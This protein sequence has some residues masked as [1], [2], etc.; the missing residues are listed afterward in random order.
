ML[1]VL[2][3]FYYYIIVYARGRHIWQIRRSSSVQSTAG[4]EVDANLEVGGVFMSCD[5]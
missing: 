5:S 1:L 3:F 4:D 2:L